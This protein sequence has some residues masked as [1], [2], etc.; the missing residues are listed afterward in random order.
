MEKYFKPLTKKEFNNYYD[1]Y[2]GSHIKYGEGLYIYSNLVK[3]FKTKKHISCD[4]YTKEQEESIEKICGEHY[5]NCIRIKGEKSIE[6][7]RERYK[8]KLKEMKEKYTCKCGE[9][10]TKG[11]KN[12]HNMNSE[13]HLNFLDL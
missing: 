7:P 3:H 6:S 10:L 11:E 9:V 5:I 13:K 2:C 4:K 12:N 1:C 8:Q